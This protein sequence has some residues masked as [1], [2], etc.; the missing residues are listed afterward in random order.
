MHSI[1]FKYDMHVIGHSQMILVGLRLIIFVL[2]SKKNSYTLRFK[3]L[4]STYIVL[5]DF[6]QYQVCI[7]TFSGLSYSVPYSPVSNWRRKG[8]CECEKIP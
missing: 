7:S 6:I 4:V 1:V 5:I 8:L 3:D 2:V